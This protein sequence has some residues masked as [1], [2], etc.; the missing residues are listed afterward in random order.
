MARIV[1]TLCPR[2]GMQLTVELTESLLA[3]ASDSP[4]GITGLAIPHRDHVAIVYFDSN[5][6]ERGVKVVE[7]AGTK[8]RL[9]VIRIPRQSLEKLENIKAFRVL[10][11]DLGLVF[12]GERGGFEVAVRGE[13]KG[14]SLDIAPSSLDHIPRLKK[15]LTYAASSLSA[16]MSVIST[17]RVIALIHTIDKL[18]TVEPPIFASKVVKL[19]FLSPL[20]TYEINR[21]R[22]NLFS[23]YGSEITA[24]YEESDLEMVIEGEG[25]PVAYILGEAGSP[26]SI[27]TALFLLALERRGI[28]EF[29]P[30]GVD[31]PW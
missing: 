5:G 25:K 15:W 14:V 21:R 22:L 30:L 9:K 19:L 10:V 4:I 2:C 7:L 6:G 3:D 11:K 8:E 18:A 1:K 17:S 28:I 24:R 27:T 31:L 29:K 12:E 16:F 13:Y 26:A 20:V 23:L